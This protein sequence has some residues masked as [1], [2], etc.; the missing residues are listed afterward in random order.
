MSL[1]PPKPATNIFARLTKTTE[2]SYKAYNIHVAECNKGQQFQ[3][4]DKKA[5]NNGYEVYSI[6]GKLGGAARQRHV[7]FYFTENAAIRSA[8]RLKETKIQKGYIDQTGHSVFKPGKAT[9]PKEERTQPLFDP[10]P[11]IKPTM[12]VAQKD[13]FSDL[14]D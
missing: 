5:T 9:K 6:F 12:T 13:R 8:N 14:I 11:K 7:G 10:I 1:P 4:S 3:G 2:G